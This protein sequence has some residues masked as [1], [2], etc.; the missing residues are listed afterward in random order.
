MRRLYAVSLFILA[1]SAAAAAAPAPEESWGK[2]GVSF[3]QY[4]QDSI[5]CGR[6]GYY[7]DISET[8]DAKEF[9]R[10]SRR[11]DNLNG[12]FSGNATGASGTGPA[13]ANSVDQMARFAVNQQR[14]IE[15]VRPEERFRNLKRTLQSATD[16]CL[17]GRGYSKF[18]LT[19][20]Q[21][22]QLKKL[23][24][25]SDERHAYLFRLGSD[26]AVLAAQVVTPP[27]TR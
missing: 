10:A 2:A 7:L 13:S 11:L 15:S 9:A 26:P 4:R 24:V 21:R 27:A 3:Q 18:A 8:A 5:E 25:G 14:I 1:S 6:E 17:I 19:A 23:K 16:A 12:T 22:R 20:A